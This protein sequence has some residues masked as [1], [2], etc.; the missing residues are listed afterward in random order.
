MV[1]A[2][3]NRKMS[4]E[5]RGNMTNIMELCSTSGLV[6]FVLLTGKAFDVYGPSSPFTI[7]AGCDLTVAALAI[8]LGCFG[9][10]KA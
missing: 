1:K 9:V 10:L 5:I 8:I 4:K 3:Y 2:W 6:I 7:L